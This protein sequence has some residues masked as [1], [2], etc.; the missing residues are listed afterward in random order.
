MDVLGG[1]PFLKR[2]VAERRRLLMTRIYAKRIIVKLRLCQIIKIVSL[3]KLEEDAVE[4]HRQA[5]HLQF[6]KQE[7]EIKKKEKKVLLKNEE[8]LKKREVED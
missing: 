7:K 5:R 6:M 2:R 8:N 4:F 1:N 3:L